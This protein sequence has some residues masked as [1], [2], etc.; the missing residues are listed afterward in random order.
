M[1]NYIWFVMIFLGLLVGIFTGNGEGISNVIISSI[2]RTVT[3]I[4]GNV[5]LMCFWCGVL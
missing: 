2:N 5:G 1:I 3:F 4:I